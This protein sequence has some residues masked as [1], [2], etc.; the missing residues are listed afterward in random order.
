MFW[1]PTLQKSITDIEIDDCIKHIQ[2][3]IGIILYYDREIDVT[4]IIAQSNI[5]SVKNNAN[6]KTIT[7][8]IHLLD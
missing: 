5:Q 1:F 4:L 3:F 6:Q 7:S 8:L 2:I